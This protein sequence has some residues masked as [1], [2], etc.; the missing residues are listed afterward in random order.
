MSRDTGKENGNYSVIMEYELG[1][2]GIS[3]T[4]HIGIIIPY[5][6]LRTTE[7]EEFTSGHKL[8]NKSSFFMHA[9]VRVYIGIDVYRTQGL[10][11]GSGG[12]SN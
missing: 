1:Y 4:Y 12:L 11:G 3:W 10:L 7:S 2:K 9:C 6:L 8:P 5:S